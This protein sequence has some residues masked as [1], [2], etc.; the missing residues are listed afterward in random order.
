M[1]EARV[2]A[3]AERYLYGGQESENIGVRVIGG[4]IGNL[5]MWTEDAPEFILGEQVLV[6]L[7]RPPYALE[8]VPK[9]VDPLSY[10]NVSIQSKYR[11]WHGIL[12]NWRGGGFPVTCTW[13]VEAKI[14][15]VYDE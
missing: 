15:A 14:A 8:P 3:R 2:I 6:I 12:T 7:T 10:Y 11:Y 9:G 5:V 1:E 13:F 4:R